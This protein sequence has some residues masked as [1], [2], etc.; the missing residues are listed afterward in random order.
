[1]L[2]LFTWNELELLI[3]GKSVIDLELLRRHTE[4]S[5]CSPSDNH[6]NFF[7]NILNS[8]NEDMKRKFIRFAWAQE[9]FYFY[10]FAINI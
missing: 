10:F 7:W 5:G 3:C 2:S 6:I 4:Y 9:V 1:M 8:F